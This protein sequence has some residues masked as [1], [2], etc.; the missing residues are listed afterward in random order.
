M[1]RVGNELFISQ[2]AI[3]GSHS[4]IVMALQKNEVVFTR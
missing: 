4:I 3:R 2:L 1:V